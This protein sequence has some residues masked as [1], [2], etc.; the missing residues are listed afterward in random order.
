MRNEDVSQSYG[1]A[2]TADMGN[3]SCSCGG[4][5]MSYT[6]DDQIGH[7]K[8]KD[9]AVASGHPH[10]SH[11]SRSTHG[12]HSRVVDD[13]DDD[14]S[15]LSVKFYGVNVSRDVKPRQSSRMKHGGSVKKSRY[16]VDSLKEQSNLC[17]HFGDKNGRKR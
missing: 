15:M 14:S 6:G 11:S 1:S 7:H 10:R 4:C 5:G 13:E 12:T 3:S 8:L 9:G 17:D 16:S 2:H